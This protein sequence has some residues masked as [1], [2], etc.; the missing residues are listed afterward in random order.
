MTAQ[1]LFL[2]MSFQFS[3]SDDRTRHETLRNSIFLKLDNFSVF[4]NLDLTF[5]SGTAPHPVHRGAGVSRGYAFLPR[6]EVRSVHG[7]LAPASTP[8]PIGGVGVGFSRALNWRN[9][10]TAEPKHV[11]LWW[12]PAA[13][14]QI[15]REAAFCIS[16]TVFFFEWALQIRR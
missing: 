6:W 13:L 16:N 4:D 14:V 15:G 9:A 1:L 5:R 7:R 12:C 2:L 11:A 8:S 10:E 3:S